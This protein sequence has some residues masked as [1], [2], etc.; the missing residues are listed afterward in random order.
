MV[1]KRFRNK[2]HKDHRINSVVFNYFNI[3]LLI[4]SSFIGGGL[5]FILYDSTYSVTHQTL[6][7]S[8]LLL[9]FIFGLIIICFIIISEFIEKLQ[10]FKFLH[11]K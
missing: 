7:I 2:I 8:G 3:S 5:G 1:I 4:A 10:V 11:K 9:G 6:I